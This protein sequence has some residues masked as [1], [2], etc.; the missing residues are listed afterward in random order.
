M[1]ATILAVA[2]LVL[3]GAAGTA[4]AEPAFRGESVAEWQKRILDAG[5]GD[6]QQTI[7]LRL[8]AGGAD[9]VP[10]LVGL[11]LSPEL[12]VAAI[13][14]SCLRIIGPDAKSAAPA[15]AKVAREG[16][17]GLSFLA[18]TALADIGAEPGAAADALL[19]GLTDTSPQV[20]LLAAKTLGKVGEAGA[21]RSLPGLLA[22]LGDAEEAV[23]MEAADSIVKCGP[24]AAETVSKLVAMVTG[25][26]GRERSAAVYALGRIGAPAAPA[27]ATLGGILRDPDDGRR[28][29]AA[30][31]LARIGGAAEPELAKTVGDGSPTTRLLAAYSLALMKKTSAPAIAV[32]A[33]A[34]RKAPP[35]HRLLAATALVALGGAAAGARD[36]LLAVLAD[37]DFEIAGLAAR[38]LGC[39]GDDPAVVAG[40][41]A[42]LR[43]GAN[44]ARRFAATAVSLIGPRAAALVPEL[45]VLDESED[46]VLR[47]EVGKALRSFGEVAVSRYGEALAHPDPDIRWRAACALHRVGPAAKTELPALLKALG[48]GSALVRSGAEDAVAAIGR[49]AGPG[50]VETLGSGPPPAR[51]AAARLLGKLESAAPT[52]A[53]EALERA[54]A[55]GDDALKAAATEALAKLRPADAGPYGPLLLKLGDEDVLARSA[56]AKKLVAAGAPAVPAVVGL[57]SDPARAEKAIEVLGQMGAAAKEAVPALIEIFGDPTLGYPATVALLSI[58]PGAVPA[59]IAALTRPEAKIRAGAARTLGE[60]G[61]Y[62]AAAAPALQLLLSDSNERVRKAAESAL[63]RLRAR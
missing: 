7:C 13:G 44:Q 60:F 33:A 51:V 23:A 5:D 54:A 24:A 45:L 43:T 18:G 6:E 37:T 21:S 15:L 62:G 30:E 27:V 31:A 48:D 39:L 57:L 50:L 38:C 2:V 47:E 11:A 36:D 61:P 22:A 59:L 55:E 9:A 14:V 3:L 20:R 34:L 41:G 26:V 10:V 25:G 1:R 4:A 35:E 42:A 32:L 46:A 19:P 8:I 52:G 40:L 63:A 53:A 16:P 28:L 12:R 56:A 49:E 17:R 29:V 58:G